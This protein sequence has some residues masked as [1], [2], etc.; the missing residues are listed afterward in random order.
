M[1]EMNTTDLF[2][3]LTNK[4]WVRIH[5]ELF[6]WPIGQ[7][8]GLISGQVLGAAKITKV[9]FTV[10]DKDLQMMRMENDAEK[11]EREAESRLR[12]ERATKQDCWRCIGTQVIF[13]DGMGCCDT[14]GM[15][16]GKKCEP[17]NF[18]FSPTLEDRM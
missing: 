17:I 7:V 16:I 14:C 13:E 5:W 2:F 8:K 4:L 10:W 15:L 12:Y 9:F 3:D 11:A 18:T 6:T 1:R